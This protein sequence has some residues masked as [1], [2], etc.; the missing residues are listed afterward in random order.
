MKTDFDKITRRFLLGEAKTKPSIRAYTESVLNILEQ[1]VSRSQRESRQVSIAKQ[2]LN[3][4]RKLN[5][6]LEEKINLLEEQ[7]KILEEGK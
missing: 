6:R 3:E 5:R 7:I 4:I 1:F 2:H